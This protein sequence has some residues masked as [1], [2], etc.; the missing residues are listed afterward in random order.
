MP[1]FS[2]ILATRDRPQLSAEAFDSILAQG[3]QDFEVVIVDDGTSEENWQQ[4]QG[5]IEPAR[6][7]LGDRLQV[8]RLVRR[9]NGHGQSYSINF[10]AAHARG[11]YLAILDD[12][13]TWTDSGHLAR[14]KAA[15]EEQPGADLYMANQEAFLLGKPVGEKLWLSALEG[16]LQAAG[17]LPEADG[18]YA[19]GVRD[20]TGTPGFCHV[21]CLIVR[22]GLFEA[23]GG[24][25]EG[26]RWECDRDLFLRLI[27]KAGVML[28][29]PAP[30]ARHNVPDPSKTANM[31]TAMPML[32]KRLHQLRVVEKAALFSS[33][34]PIRREGFKHRGFVMKKI[35]DELAASGDWAAAAHY[36]RSAL[37]A[38]PTAGWAAKTAWYS[39]KGIVSPRAKG[40]QTE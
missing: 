38:G 5:W 18:T 27:D 3:C 36:A 24:M 8:H 15:L 26:I 10:G 34:E 32:Q 23:I 39:L 21:N 37:G 9:P 30:V 7:R 19:V 20:L 25:D 33:R 4:Y 31:T 13:D 12:D 40:A 35:A 17:E 14:A 22:R 16:R 2:V 29:N 28:H 11:T 6:A 1:F